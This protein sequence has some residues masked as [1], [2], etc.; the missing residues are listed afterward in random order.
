MARKGYPVPVRYKSLTLVAMGYSDAE[1]GSQVGVPEP[2]IRRWR[3]DPR[4]AQILRECQQDLID[5]MGENARLALSHLRGVLM[6][7]KEEPSRQMTAATQSLKA[8]SRAVA[9]A[10]VKQIGDAV[11]R[12]VT[13][14]ELEEKRRA[15]LER[16]SKLSDLPMTVIDAEQELEQEQPENPD[17]VH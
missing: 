11:E 13:A 7:S 3:I 4:N 5:R 12:M 8:Y 6:D 1:V 2:T 17:A 9:A 14:K 15:V 10:G 16:V